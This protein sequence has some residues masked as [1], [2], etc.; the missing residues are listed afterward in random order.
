MINVVQSLINSKIDNTPVTLTVNLND[1]IVEYTGVV[2][3]ID[4][5]N[6]VVTM[7]SVRPWNARCTPWRDGDVR[8]FVLQ[9]IVERNETT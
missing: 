2:T 4:Y 3:S 9:S 5:K 1:E 6:D 8:K 7:K